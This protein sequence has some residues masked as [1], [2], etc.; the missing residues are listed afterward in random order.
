VI[1]GVVTDG[2]LKG[3]AVNGEYTII[4]PCVGTANCIE[5]TLDIIKRH[6]ND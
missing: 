4:P 3:H 1:T 2:W 5:V 6:S